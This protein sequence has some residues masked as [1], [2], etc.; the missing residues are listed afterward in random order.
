MSLRVLSRLTAAAV[1]LALLSG[2]LPASPSVASSA[3]ASVRTAL[4]KLRLDREAGRIDLDTYFRQCFRVVFHPGNAAPEYRPSSGDGPW[5]LTP[6]IAE[7]ERARSHLSSVTTE[8]IDGFLRP[9]RR[10]TST[11][12]SPAG[13]FSLSYFTSGLDAVDGTD[14]NPANGIP[15]MVEFCAEYADSCWS[16]IAGTFGFPTPP[17]PQD[18][19]YDILLEWLPN[20][21]LGACGPTGNAPGETQIWVRNRLGAVNLPVDDPEGN[22]RGRAKAIIAHEFKHATQYVGSLWTEDGYVELDA[23]WV[24]D[25]VY[26]EHNAYN[27]YI[28][29]DGVT[30]QLSHPEVSLDD[31]A[32][33]DD[34]L[35]EQY[36]YER[37]GLAILREFWD[38]RAADTTEAVLDTYRAVQLAHGADWDD[39]YPEYME[40]CW[41]S[42]TNWDPSLG[43]E[44]AEGLRDMALLEAPVIAYPHAAADSVPRLAAHVRRFEPGI[45]IARISFD[46]EDAAT[47]FVVSIVEERENGAFQVTRPALDAGNSFT[48]DASASWSYLAYVAVIVTNAET[49]GPDRSY[50]LDVSDEPAVGGP[51][52]ADA[53]G[54]RLTIAPNPF[55]DFTMIRTNA[56]SGEPVVVT[57]HDL[58][59]R[60]VRRLTGDAVVAWRG[61]DDAGRLVPAGVYWAR[62]SAGDVVGSRRITRIR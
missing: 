33:Y 10:G 16:A 12:V 38:R 55:V 39:S 61:R 7:Y 17:L 19:T 21:V 47:G 13:L 30:S 22:K 11:Y 36:L 25:A 3:P 53:I 50:T 27:A 24:M 48:Y 42:G 40:W 29:P 9:G 43:F 59:G 4:E 51:M 14:E 28:S 37:H 23:N 58:A 2:P 6:W 20:N 62:V 1:V 15:D 44:E 26:D 52:L 54:D 57:I 18:G 41:F 56:R 8:E 45:G 60:R 32:R 5:C 34:L 35:W 46:G 49:A 31:D